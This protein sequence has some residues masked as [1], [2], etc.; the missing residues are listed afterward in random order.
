MLEDVVRSL[1]RKLFDKGPWIFQKDSASAYKAKLMQKWLEDNVPDF[2]HAEDLPS[3]SPD[4]FWQT[5]ESIECRKIHRNIESL[6]KVK[7]AIVSAV[8]SID[9]AHIREAINKFTERLYKCIFTEGE[10]LNKNYI[11]FSSFFF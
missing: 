9:I 5:V 2:I 1:T 11:I 8:K 3:C 6:K 10:I 7:K 4:N